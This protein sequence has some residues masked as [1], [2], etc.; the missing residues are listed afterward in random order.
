MIKIAIL[1]HGVVGSG[2]VQVLGQNR[3][4]IEKQAGCGISVKRVLDIRNFS[5]ELGPLYT[6]DIETI[7]KDNEIQIVV[8]AMGG[9]EPA[10]DYIKQALYAGKHVCTSNKEV[11][12]KHGA[13]LISIAKK[14]DI[15]FLFEASVGGGI[16]VI[17]PI[18]LVLTTDTVIS[19]SGILN[20]TSNFMLTQMQNLN[21]P[22]SE[23]LKEAQQLGYAESDP[24]ADVGGYDACRKLAIL[25]SITTGKHVEYEEILTN[26]IQE[27][28]EADFAF[29]QALGF[30]IK[31]MV[32]G[33]ITES[34][35]KAVSAPM[36]VKLGSPIS[37][38]QGVYNGVL[39]QAKAVGTVMF[40]GQGAGQQP[41]AA[42]VI[43]DI[44]DIAKH[45]KG[46]IPFTWLP[47]KNT[48]LPHGTYT[49]RKLIRVSYKCL[50]KLQELAKN[51]SIIELPGYPGQAAWITEPE[52]EKE[53]QTSF[54]NLDECVEL[55]KIL[56]IF[57]C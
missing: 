6:N 44:V 56:R 4:H 49:S 34:G 13:E 3:V 36:L 17:R 22:Y 25:L 28:E 38:I 15:N 53:T 20:G 29:A 57:D 23:A 7:L 30:T 47:E 46:H 55:K 42:A 35:I 52:T 18:N 48:V 37:A 5:N 39:V 21:K 50:E 27:I 9:L 54:E 14:Q 26:G 1:G 8:E 12:S 33:H 51:S 2:V 45:L 11:V 32:N 43:S 40:Y 41:T 16:P 19:I 24:A 10:Y 31:P